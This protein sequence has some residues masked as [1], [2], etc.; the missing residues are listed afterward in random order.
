MR[1]P[2]SL[3]RRT[4][5][6]LAGLGVGAAL[7]LAPVSGASAAPAAAHPSV[8]APVAVRSAPPVASV[9]G[10][11]VSR[12]TIKKRAQNWIDR[13]IPYSQSHYA[14]EPGASKKYRQDCS[15]YVSMAWHAKT[16]YTTLSITE[17]SH[18]IAYKSLKNGDAVWYRHDGHGHIVLFMGWTSSAHTKFNVWEEKGTGYVALK[19]TYTVKYAKS[20]GFSAI[21]YDHIKS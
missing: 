12:A 18:G 6:G 11:A 1:T 8:V 3:T 7:V 13:K 5:T 19:T 17:V 2:R 9:A 16:S 14:T 21:R 4:V 20:A 15:G 10:D